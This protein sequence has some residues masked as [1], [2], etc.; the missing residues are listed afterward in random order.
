VV[1]D[2]GDGSDEQN[3][4]ERFQHADNLQP[5][6]GD[7]QGRNVWPR[8][9]RAEHAFQILLEL[10]HGDDGMSDI[11][12]DMRAVARCLV[13][14]RCNCLRNSSGTSGHELLQKLTDKLSMAVQV[15]VISRMTSARDC[16]V[17]ASLLTVFASG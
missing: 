2:G 13:A 5:A 17:R 1:A 14:A 8:A 6:T 12:S 10:P 4:Y 3:A 11:M 9:T 16:R 7:L 15:A